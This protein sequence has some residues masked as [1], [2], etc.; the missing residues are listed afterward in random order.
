MDQEEFKKRLE[1]LSPRRREVLNK[2]LTGQSY[3]AI[4]KSLGIAEGTLRKHVSAIYD[5]LVGDQFPDKSRIRFSD[6]ETLIH[7]YQPSLLKKSS[8][9]P[10]PRDTYIERPPIERVCQ[11]EIQQPGALLFIKAPPK[12]G[13]TMLLSQVI[14]NIPQEDYRSVVL[15]VRLAAKDSINTQ[16]HQEEDKKN[17]NDLLYWF[18]TSVTQMLLLSG[19]TIGNKEKNNISNQQEFEKFWETSLGDSL[20][21]CTTFFEKY[22]LSE[23]KPLVLGL[24]DLDFLDFDS[25]FNENIASDFFMMLRAWHEKAAISPIWDNLRLILVMSRE[26]TLNS[27]NRSSPLANIG[28]HIKLPDFTQDQV[29]DLALRYQLNWK[30]EQ[31]EKLMNLVEGHPYL[32]HEA[33]ENIARWGKNLEDIL[34]NA[35]TAAG[36]YNS[37]LLDI[38]QQF[39]IEIDKDKKPVI[40]N[41]TLDEEKRTKNKIEYQEKIG[42]LKSPLL[43]SFKELINNREVKRLEPRIRDILDELGL[44]KLK[45]NLIILR[46]ELYGQFFRQQLQYLEN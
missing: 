45:G 20:V 18:C 2:L 24:D 28:T 14:R 25:Q 33:M 17:I 31:I 26:N 10:S 6:L 41:P 21:K 30:N 38:L 22:L 34:E 12:M 19:E 40:A 39:K 4:A 7:K 36:I 27:L 42:S 13:K 29:T 32:I 35:T 15:S 16:T 23:K 9:L 3:E 44:I 1:N 5:E 8:P 46:C 37:Y 11:Q 43:E